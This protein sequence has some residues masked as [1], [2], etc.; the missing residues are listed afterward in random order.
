MTQ[1]RDG[2]ASTAL[3]LQQEDEEVGSN[4]NA[5]LVIR[6]GMLIDGSGNAPV[7][8]EAIVIEGNRVRSVGRLPGD[9]N[10]E[11]RDNVVEIDAAGQWIL[12][13][14]IDAHVHLSF[15]NPAIPNIAISKGTASAEF[16]TLRAARN[17]QTVLRAGVTSISCPGGTWFTE[18]ALREA[19]NAGLIEGPRI[20]CAG[21]FIINYGSIGDDEPSWVG[22]PEHKIGVL[23]NTVEEMVTEARRQLKHGVDYIKL[24]DS[25][26]G[27]MQTISPEEMR[28]VV[29]EAHRRNSRVT[30]HSRGSGT[31]RAAAEAGMDWIIHADLAT[32]D[33]IEAVAERG[34]PIMPTLCNLTNALDLRRRQGVPEGSLD[35]L[36]RNIEG[37]TGNFQLI[38]KMGITALSGTDTGNSQGAEYGVHHAKEAEIMVRDVGYTPLEAISIM[39]RNNAFTMGLQDEVGVV[40][41]GKLA[42]ITIWKGD[43]VANISVLQDPANLSAIIKD[44]RSVDLNG[45]ESNGH[46]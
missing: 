34:I 26:W 37:S 30:I 31:T 44:G 23:A 20:A 3:S 13:G 17:A 29:D 16:N 32:E 12:P 11:D 14:L 25:L 9:V 46:S 41:A 35:T 40:A 10:L 39:T 27:D 43:P 33:D 38:R 18:V 6:N 7:Q 28:Q 22:V 2:G 24:A 19:I 45:G 5:T 36:K 4:G 15:G 21:R 42:D 8:N 1:I